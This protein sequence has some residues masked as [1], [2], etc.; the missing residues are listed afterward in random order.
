[1]TRRS[2]VAGRAWL[3]GRCD[4]RLCSLEGFSEEVGAEVQVSFWTDFCPCLVGWL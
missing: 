1:M 2:R 4:L 3:W